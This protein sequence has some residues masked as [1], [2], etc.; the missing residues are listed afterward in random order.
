MSMR[1]SEKKR[2]SRLR[3]VRVLMVIILFAGLF[4]QITMLARISSENKRADKAGEEVANLNQYIEN[5]QRDI[6]DYRNSDE[7]EQLARSMG[8]QDPDASQLR[9]I[10][11]SGLEG[12]PAQAAGK[13]GAEKDNQ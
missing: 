4:V 12:T 1:Y 6:D 8:M 13:N 10:Y 11:V 2:P 7:I 9:S 3:F 5:L